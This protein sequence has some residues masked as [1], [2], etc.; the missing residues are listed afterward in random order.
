LS[1]HHRPSSKHGALQ[2]TFSSSLL[3]TAYKYS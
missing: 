1:F 3:K 2:W